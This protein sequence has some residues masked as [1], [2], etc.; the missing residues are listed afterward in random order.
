MF[1]YSF[2][3]KPSYSEYGAMYT[4]V[5]DCISTVI[6]LMQEDDPLEFKQ[7]FEHNVEYLYECIEKG[8]I[9]RVGD[10]EQP[11]IAEYFMT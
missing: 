4:V 1:V 7:E 10:D 9:I 5:A 3:C 8:A 11:R 6:N 2:W